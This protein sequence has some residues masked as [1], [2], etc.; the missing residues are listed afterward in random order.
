MQDTNDPESFHLLQISDSASDSLPDLDLV[1]HSNNFKKKKVRLKRRDRNQSSS[2]GRGG[3]SG[4]LPGVKT[5]G[6]GS[7]DEGLCGL[8]VPGGASR[9]N[10]CYLIIISSSAIILLLVLAYITSSLHT[11]IVSL[12][13]QLRMKIADDDSN[14]S[15]LQLL[16]SQV[17]SVLSNQ[18]QVVEKLRKVGLT[19]EASKR[20]MVALNSSL[21]Q[22]RHQADSE[23]LQLTEVRRDLELLTNISRNNEDSVKQITDILTS[24]NVTHQ[25][26]LVNTKGR[27]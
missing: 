16:D 20:A 22:D 2:H 3:G 9:N 11:R 12:E 18:S 14:D 10:N 27:P 1:T 19:V 17:Q 24:L 21:L 25:L 26:S 5:G 8:V 7:E 6:S 23:T 15:K 13:Q 4:S